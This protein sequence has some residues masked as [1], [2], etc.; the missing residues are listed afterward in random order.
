MVAG[1]PTGQALPAGNWQQISIF[2]SPMDVHVN[3]MPS[4]AASRK[5]A[6]IRAGFSRRTVPRREI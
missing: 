5:C 1:D 6:I 4:A 3:R 2:L